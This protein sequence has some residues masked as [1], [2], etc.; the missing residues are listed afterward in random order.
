MKSAT[1]Q[2]ASPLAD[3][4]QYQRIRNETFDDMFAEG[5]TRGAIPAS[6]AVRATQA[7]YIEM[8]HAFLA[9]FAAYVVVGLIH[10]VRALCTVI[11]RPR[12]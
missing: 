11:S 6:R 12:S 10:W 9:R 5:R 3:G 1:P 7:I 2:L 8:R 4:E